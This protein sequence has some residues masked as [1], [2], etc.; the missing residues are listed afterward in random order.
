MDIRRI[1]GDISVSPQISPGDIPAIAA[2]GFRSVLCNRPD[3]EEPGQPDY[4][5]VA[6]AARDAGLEVRSVPIPLGPTPAATIRDFA[7][8]LDEMER[9][10]L[11][12]CRSGTRCTMLWSMVSY[13]ALGGDEVIRRARAAGY[14]M[15]GLIRQIERG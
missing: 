14:D 4:A 12:Y 8:A 2:A 15:A 5:A 1:T 11:A 7:R 9:P 13:E 3:D 6:E 10:V